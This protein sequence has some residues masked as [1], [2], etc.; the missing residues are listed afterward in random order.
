MKVVV[1]GA[2]YAGTIAANRLAGKARDAEI[3][4]INPRS[5]FVERVRL[6]EQVAAT[7]AASTPLTSMLRGGITAQLGIID[8]IGDG[9]ITLDD[10]GSDTFDYLFLAVG[11]TFVPLPGAVAVVNLPG[12]CAHLFP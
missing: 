10:G 12:F 7:G 6:H 2:G 4:V 1:V 9:G 8:K 3:T 5:D 11:S